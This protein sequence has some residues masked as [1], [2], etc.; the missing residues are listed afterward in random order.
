[1]H[2]LSDDPSDFKDQETRYRFSFCFWSGFSHHLTT[3]TLILLKFS[4]PDGSDSPIHNTNCYFIY[5]YLFLFVWF[6]I[7]FIV[8]GAWN[9]GAGLRLGMRIWMENKGMSRLL[10]FLFSGNNEERWW[11]LIL[12][13]DETSDRKCRNIILYQYG[14]VITKCWM[15]LNID[16]QLNVPKCIFLLKLL[17]ITFTS[18]KQK[19][20]DKRLMCNR[21]HW[22][23]L[24]ASLMF[25]W[26]LHISTIL[27]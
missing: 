5:S 23:N 24:I 25:K 18:F 11:G 22:L 19:H 13:T 17:K 12:R 3:F 1:M 21:L 14:Q 6:P 7:M 26:T 20:I 4:R 8:G 16:T 10:I 2:R 15:V 9:K 27:L